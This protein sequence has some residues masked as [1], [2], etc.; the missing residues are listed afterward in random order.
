MK[1]KEKYLTQKKFFLTLFLLFII[2]IIAI[3]AS[4]LIGNVDINLIKA[5]KGFRS[6]ENNV[7]AAIL[8]KTRLP[9]TILAVLVGASLAVTGCT[10]QSLLRNPLA[11]P[12]I[13]GISSG[14]SF[15][16]VLLI[17]TGISFNLL[18]I[19]TH[20]FAAFAFSL[21]SMIFVYYLSNIKGNISTSTMLLAGIT[22]NFFFAS[23]ILL[24]QY[25]S[26]PSQSFQMIR[27]MMGGVDAID[28]QPVIVMLIF[29][30]PGLIICILLSKRLNLI[31]ADSLYASQVGID[32]DMTRKI[33]FFISSVMTAASISV[34]GPIG[35][36]GLIVPHML[37]L[38]IG[39]DNRLLI[40]A[41]AF[42]GGIFLLLSD[43]IGRS[44][45]K[46]FFLI[47]LSHFL[48]DGFSQVEVP[49]GVITSMCG[50]PFFI[51]L[52]LKKRDILGSLE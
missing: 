21:L 5:L 42:L 9:R 24:L 27:W 10:F 48:G 39:S 52:L 4:P 38:V 3:F 47:G 37:R 33:F 32:V 45:G 35:F 31:A 49:V 46:I 34:C 2:L 23:G 40:P 11:T 43:T 41:S 14:G 1:N 28:Y 51:F 18:G 16:V 13:L 8:F 22:I 19:P 30:F 12:Y 36:V 26:N 29:S 50:A 15:G 6:Y 17:I 44:I 20:F 25:L 7:D